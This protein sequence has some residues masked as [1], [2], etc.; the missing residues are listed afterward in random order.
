[1]NDSETWE[2]IAANINAFLRI[3]QNKRGLYSYSVDVGATEYEKK[4]K[5]VHVNV[6]LQ[7]TRIV[8]QINL[9]FFI[10]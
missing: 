2:A 5:S 9:T 6:M 7:P 3:I 10:K 4:T 1:M 8:E